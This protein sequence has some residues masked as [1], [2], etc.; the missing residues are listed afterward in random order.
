MYLQGCKT[1]KHIIEIEY[2]CPK[3]KDRVK[4][5]IKNPYIGN[6]QYFEDWSYT[7]I[8]VDKCPSCGSTNHSFE[9]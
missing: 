7:Y 6:G 2:T 3:T 9:L 4:K 8:N 5:E 1:V